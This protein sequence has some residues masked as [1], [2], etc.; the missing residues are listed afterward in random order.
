MLGGMLSGQTSQN[1][2]L[3]TSL[4]DA[5]GDGSVLDDISD[6]LSG[7]GKKKGGLAG[8]LYRV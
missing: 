3:I 7:S 1:Q 6:M 2:D 8:M 5:D 4:I